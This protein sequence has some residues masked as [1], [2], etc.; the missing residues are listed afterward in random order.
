MR[1]RSFKL[2]LIIGLALLVD[3]RKA[4]LSQVVPASSST[5]LSECD[6]PLKDTDTSPMTQRLKAISSMFGVPKF[7]YQYWVISNDFQDV[8]TLPFDKTNS[9]DEH[10]VKLLSSDGVKLIEEN[11]AQL[12]VPL[13][14]IKQAM[15]GVLIREKCQPIHKTLPMSLSKNIVDVSFDLGDAALATIVEEALG[16][17]KY[18]RT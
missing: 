2:I 3:V 14:T 8:L 12:E 5:I 10:F 4:D 1:F 11:F 7:D 9:T 15:I 17:I 18:M 13:R 6:P 16:A